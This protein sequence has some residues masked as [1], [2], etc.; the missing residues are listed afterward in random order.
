MST[1][2]IKKILLTKLEDSDQLLLKQDSI[3]A[4]FDY[5]QLNFLAITEYYHK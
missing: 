1:L 5:S 3:H 2:P 4:I